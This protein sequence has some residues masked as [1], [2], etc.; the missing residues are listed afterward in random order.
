MRYEF[1]SVSLTN[2][3][4]DESDM[5]L[6][7]RKILIDGFVEDEAT[8]ALL[9]LGE[10]VE[11]F[12]LVARSAEGDCLLLHVLRI[13]CITAEDNRTQRPGILD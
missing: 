9:K 4:L 8:V 5:V 10:S 1:T 3:F 2:A 6:V 12:D 11:G 13:R 7:Q